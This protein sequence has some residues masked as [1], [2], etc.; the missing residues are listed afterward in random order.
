MKKK[1]EISKEKKLCTKKQTNKQKPELT[2]NK[3]LVSGTPFGLDT[4][5]WS[6][7]EM[8]GG[9]RQS[10]TLRV[11]LSTC[12]APSTVVIIS[13]P[14]CYHVQSYHILKTK[15]MVSLITQVLQ[16]FEPKFIWHPNSTLLP[17]K[18]RSVYSSWTQFAENSLDIKSNLASQSLSHL[19]NCNKTKQR[20][21]VLYS[22]RKWVAVTQ[23]EGTCI[24]SYPAQCKLV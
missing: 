2:V 17:T 14:S 19:N 9:R 8:V 7:T 6:I 15:S 4:A 20:Q 18:P 23:H 13:Y 3:C 11:K 1:M 5:I 10:V 22:Q 24:L 16:G 21:V 12:E